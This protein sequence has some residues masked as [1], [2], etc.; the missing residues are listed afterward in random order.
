MFE[1]AASVAARSPHGTYRSFHHGEQGRWLLAPF[2]GTASES[3]TGSASHARAVAKNSAAA[4][5]TAADVTR[6]LG[7]KNDTSRSHW[8]LVNSGSP[9]IVHAA[10]DE[11]HRLLEYAVLSDSYQVKM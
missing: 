10:P 3:G 4:A 1:N 8:A 11:G 5:S 9:V 7:G 6:R 2:S